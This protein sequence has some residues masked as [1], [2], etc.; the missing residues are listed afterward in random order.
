MHNSVPEPSCHP[1]QSRHLPAQF[2]D[3]LLELPLPL[4]ADFPAAPMIPHVILHVFD[5]FH[6]AFNAFGIAQ[7]YHHCP[8]YDPNSFLSPSELSGARLHVA[9]DSYADTISMLPPWPFQMMSVWRLMKWMLSGSKQ[10]SEAEVDRLISTVITVEDFQ[11]EDLQHFSAHRELRW[12]NVSEEDL[13]PDYVFCKDGW[14]ETSV[15][16]K[17]PTH[18]QKPDGNGQI[19][20]VP[21]F[22][23]H[24]LTAVSPITGKEQWLYDELYTSNAWIKAHDKVQKQ[25]HDDGCMLEQVIAGLML[26]SDATH[27]T[28]FGHASAWPVYLF[29]RNQSKYMQAQPNSLGACHLM[30]FIPKIPQTIFNFISQFMKK[31]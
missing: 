26:S 1:T 6:S 21:S 27:L 30:A 16:I 15:S 4:A 5:S 14:M 24:K 17:I 13:R 19:F 20:V 22:F 10:K 2:R 7:E 25:R 28:Q 8:T 9:A 29:F 31:N 23:Y 18:D 11:P 12:F 3:I